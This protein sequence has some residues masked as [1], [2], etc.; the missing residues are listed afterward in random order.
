M[1]KHAPGTGA[2]GLSRRYDH[3][4]EQARYPNTCVIKLSEVQCGRPWVQRQQPVKSSQALQAASQPAS[5]RWG[6]N[7]FMPAVD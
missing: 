2:G 1:L 5:V 4:R 3:A 7:L 6:M